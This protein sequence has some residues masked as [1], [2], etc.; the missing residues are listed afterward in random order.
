MGSKSAKPNET[1]PTPHAIYGSDPRGD[2]PLIHHR[3]PL[4]NGDILTRTFTALTQPVR[5]YLIHVV[6]F[7]RNSNE[8][9]GQPLKIAAVPDQ[10]PVTQK[11]TGDGFCLKHIQF[12]QNK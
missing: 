11:M 5:Q 8:L 10:Y 9:I 4:G 1:I 7:Q 3:S 6:G 2:L 12:C